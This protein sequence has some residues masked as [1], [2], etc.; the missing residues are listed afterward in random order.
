M[1]EPDAPSDPI[2]NALWEQAVACNTVAHRIINGFPEYLHH[3]AYAVRGLFGADDGRIKAFLTSDEWVYRAM[4]IVIT[5]T[6]PGIDKI[7]PCTW[8]T[9]SHRTMQGMWKISFW[10]IP[11]YEN[12]LVSGAESRDRMRAHHAAFFQI[13]RDCLMR[14]RHIR[15]SRLH[16]ESLP[17]KRIADPSLADEKRRLQDEFERVVEE[18]QAVKARQDAEWDEAAPASVVEPAPA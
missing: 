15:L 16:G 10:V 13:Y 8:T 11:Q 2:A 7:P 5:L 1:A 18:R 14:L 6:P 4:E 17:V 12:K 3:A 9:A